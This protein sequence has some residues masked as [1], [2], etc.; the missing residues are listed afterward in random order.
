MP[1]ASGC[2]PLTSH[3]AHELLR[4]VHEH[5][6][7]PFGDQHGNGPIDLLLEHAD[8]GLVTDV[9]ADVDSGHRASARPHPD[10]LF[11][12][13]LTETPAAVDPVARPGSS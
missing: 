11:A 13:L 7:R 10:M 6:L 9:L 3:E 1:T 12:L 8:R 5:V 2:T 4:L